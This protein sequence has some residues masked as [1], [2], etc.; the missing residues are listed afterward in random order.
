MANVLFKVKV[1]RPV[2]MRDEKFIH[3][4]QSMEILKM[5]KQQKEIILGG[6]SERVMYQDTD[7]KILWGNRVAGES[8]GLSPEE[9]VGRY[10]YEVCQRRNGLCAGCPAEKTAKTG[11]QH[12]AEITTRDGKVW[13]IRAYPVRRAKGDVFGIV[14]V[15]LEISERKHLEEELLRMQ[16]MQVVGG[17]I[18][19][20][21]HD[22]NNALAAVAGHSAVLL[23]RLDP[24]HRLR[25]DVEQI[26]KAAERA[27]TLTDQ[28]LA[29]TKRQWVSYWRENLAAEVAPIGEACNDKP[30]VPKD[31]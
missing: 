30:S 1:F 12:E 10:C 21:A 19:K 25:K 5:D 4:T 31:M 28:L 22:I 6:I 29:L 8:F 23:R 15:A 9:L 24:N 13:F 16:R 7:M 11:Q 14:H 17:L 2:P 27:A 3:G 18:S 26:E 20:I